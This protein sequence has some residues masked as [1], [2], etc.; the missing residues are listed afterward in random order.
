MSWTLTKFGPNLIPK[1]IK[2]IEFNLILF[3]F[4]K[5]QITN[6]IFITRDNKN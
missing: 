3:Y 5:N 4:I 1:I 6:K 2:R